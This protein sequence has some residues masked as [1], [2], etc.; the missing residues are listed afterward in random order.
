MEKT[1][2]IEIQVPEKMYDLLHDLCYEK[3]ID[4]HEFCFKALVDKFNRNNNLFDCKLDEDGNV[5]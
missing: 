1:K 5:K 4:L 3:D 2:S